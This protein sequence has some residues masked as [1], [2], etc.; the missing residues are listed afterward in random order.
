MLKTPH[1]RPLPRIFFALIGLLSC[2]SPP[3]VGTKQAELAG[4]SNLGTHASRAAVVT[5]VEKDSPSTRNPF[6]TGTL[7]NHST[8]LTAAHCFVDRGWETTAYE[9]QPGV[10]IT[11]IASDGDIH[12]VGGSDQ[13]EG[14]RR[15][16]IDDSR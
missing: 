16:F 12:M 9:S 10:V 6:C 15:A 11:S 5:L 7:L 14:R 3:E 4:G 2:A 13:F 8:V 1:S